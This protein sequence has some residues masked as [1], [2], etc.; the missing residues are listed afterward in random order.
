MTPPNHPLAANGTASPIPAL[1]PELFCQFQATTRM[2]LEMQQAQQRMMERYLESQERMLVYCMQGAPRQGAG[3]AIPAPGVAQPT[4]MTAPTPDAVPATEPLRVMPAPAALRPPVLMPAVQ[5][6]LA[7]KPVLLPSVPQA[8]RPTAN[9][10]SSPTPIPIPIQIKQS[11]NGHDP[12]ATGTASGDAPPPPEIFRQDL[13]Q[14]V[15]ERTGYP[16]DML[17][18][19][20]P[21]EAGLGIDSIKTVEIFSKLKEYH[22]FFQCEGQDEEELLTEFTKLKTLRDIIDSY[23]Q[24]RRSYLLSAGSNGDGKVASPDGAGMPAAV[25]ERFAVAAV[26]APPEDPPAKKLIRTATSSS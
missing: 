15:S 25:V 1:G 19:T 9:G 12:A 5:P 13:L 22:R 6:E 16:I 3:H 26:E 10:I 7:P 23:T 8:T 4:V 18:E 24:H 21:L 14:V 11:S 17:D 20:L 2:L